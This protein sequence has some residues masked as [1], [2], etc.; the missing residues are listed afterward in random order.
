MIDFEAISWTALAYVLSSLQNIATHSHE[1]ILAFI[2]TF[3]GAYIAFRLERRDRDRERL[4][5]RNAEGNLALFTLWQMWE[6]IN[7]FKKEV[8]DV[9]PNNAGRWLNMA[10]TPPRPLEALAFDIA[11]LHFLFEGKDKNVLGQLVLEERRFHSSIALIDQRTHLMLDV[12]W[13]LLGAA[14]IERG[15]QYDEKLIISI[16]KEDKLIKAQML[17]ESLTKQITANVG[18][19]KNTFQ[20]LRTQLREMLPDMKFINVD[21]QDSPAP[22]EEV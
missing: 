17:A 10:T 18:S 13:P 4:E 15:K 6:V 2:G 20:Q 3:G 22:N 8:I 5:L 19:F 7:Q 11:K 16:I 12:I 9:A 14:G 21:F 1:L